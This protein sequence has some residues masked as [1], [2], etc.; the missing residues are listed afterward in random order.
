MLST[1]FLKDNTDAEAPLVD[2]VKYEKFQI[3]NEMIQSWEEHD[4]KILKQ[5]D[6]AYFNGLSAT[7][8]GPD[9]VG[10][11]TTG[12]LID[13]AN[14]NRIFA[15]STTSGLFLSLDNGASWNAVND[16]HKTLNYTSITQNLFDP[17]V[18]Y[19]G[20]DADDNI[21][22]SIDGGATFT[23]IALPNG[24]V[25]VFDLEHSKVSN[26][27]IFAATNDGLLKSTN[28]GLSWIELMDGEVFDVV[29]LPS[30]KVLAT[31]NQGIYSSQD[32]DPLS[33]SF[34]NYEPFTGYSSALVAK[35]AYS[36]DFPDHVYVLGKN[37]GD[38]FLMKSE[39]GGTNW[40]GVSG[41]PDLGH[42]AGQFMA[43]VVKKNDPEFI[44]IGGISGFG[45]Y[46]TDG[47]SSW[48]P[49][50]AGH[51]DQQIFLQHPANPDEFIIGNDGGIWRKNWSA[52]TDEPEDLNE[53]YGTTQFYFGD[54][55]NGMVIGGTQDNG[56][57]LFADGEWKNIRG[58][59]GFSCWISR[60]NP[61][62]AYGSIQNG[63]IYVWNNLLS[64]NPE[65]EQIG[66][67]PGDA[68]VAISTIFAMNEADDEQLYF[69]DGGIKR[70]T[71][72]G[73]SWE[74]IISDFVPT[75]IRVGNTVNPTLYY[76]GLNV[77]PIVNKLGK[78][79][80]AATASA[81]EEIDLSWK[82]P[83]DLPLGA[84]SS[85]A[86]HPQT[87]ELFI[88]S[89]SQSANHAKVWKLSNVDIQIEGP[90][91]PDNGQATQRSSGI[92]PGLPV[93]S[94]AINPVWPNNMII[95]TPYGVYET[96]DQ[97]GLWV[98]VSDI[99]NVRVDDIRATSD[100]KFVIFTY[101]RGIWELNRQDEP[102]GDFVTVPYSQNFE[103]PLDEEHWITN[104]STFFGEVTKTISIA[105]DNFCGNGKLL[106]R[107]IT[108]PNPS[109]NSATL[110]LDLKNVSEPVI[111]SF[112][113]KDNNA[114]EEIGGYADPNAGLSGI[115][116]S[117][118]AGYS[119]VK[120]SDFLPVNEYTYQT[121]DLS[122]LAASQGLALTQFMMLKF[123][124][125]QQPNQTSLIDNLTIDKNT[126]A[127]VPIL[128]SFSL[129]TNPYWTFQSTG[130]GEVKKSSEYI[131]QSVPS[132]LVMFGGSSQIGYD[133]NQAR[134]TIDLRD[135][136]PAALTFD[137]K[138]FGNE[139]HASNGV[140]FSDNGG[141]SFVKVLDLNTEEHFVYR[142]ETIMLKETINDLGLCPTRNFVIKFQHYGKYGPPM[143]G[144]LAFDNVSIIESPYTGDYTS[145][146]F[147]ENF[148]NP[149]SPS[150]WEKYAS[151]AYSQIVATQSNAYADFCSEGKLVM[152]TLINDVPSLNE[153]WLG[154]NL[155]NVLGSITL[156]FAYKDNYE[157]GG[158]TEEN[159]DPSF[160]SGLFLSN[161]RGKTFSQIA[162]IT[163]S[164]D[165]AYYTFNLS[166]LAQENNITLTETMVL[167]F[168]QYQQPGELVLIDNLMIDKGGIASTPYCEPF[169]GNFLQ[170]WSLS[171]TNDGVVR[172][173]YNPLV[174]GSGKLIMNSGP[175]SISY[176]QMR[177]DLRIDISTSND[178][179]ELSF[180]WK[181]LNNTDVQNANG[182]YLSDD[183]GLTFVKVYNLN[184]NVHNVYQN[185]VLNLTELMQANDLCATRDFVIRFQHYAKF[186]PPSFTGGF[187]FDNVCIEPAPDLLMSRLSIE[188]SFSVYPNPYTTG[189]NLSVLTN[190]E[191][192]VIELVD[193]NGKL[194]SRTRAG[195]VNESI[196][197]GI[198]K[199]LTKLA[200]IRIIP[201]DKSKRTQSTTIIRN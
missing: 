38:Y 63:H 110:K 171:K 3:T 165:F 20:T 99:P 69:I 35:I 141:A 174:K 14:T 186:G 76:A 106:L 83:E 176:D 201:D 46:S 192:V 71:D 58:A 168:Q 50:P 158:L 137:W 151:T 109:L 30:G 136:V 162:N 48:N 178:P 70:T 54:A 17:E 10:G 11:R 142:K 160:N 87:E 107:T 190:Y 157:I 78:M 124:L 65:Y 128:E 25:D 133:L 129:R 85:I 86:V 51:A 117:N 89:N 52:I 67:N 73:E 127:Q 13:V 143:A 47:G 196:E 154:I 88:T 184:T 42:Q 195:V 159:V 5:L 166:E 28:G 115:F 8:L 147:K 105:Y 41:V 23:E 198:D 200:Y 53:T 27:T 37:S 170:S 56:T 68:N 60:Q 16:Q 177:A 163:K 72:S 81:G 34:A 103:S 185:I 7:F 19:F 134:L 4:Q 199:V 172:V 55:Y 91:G 80:N 138:S 61:N 118:N 57:W 6:Q 111:V 66:P 161:D 173:D 181:S 153:A 120:I 193:G 9:K 49:F 32:G 2:F 43:I 101:G 24:V 156:S 189:G 148:E 183:G 144:G 122:A 112:A 100:G 90:E 188:N 123:Q 82:L 96:L 108:N 167:K 169:S 114:N 79:V 175:S 164:N 12:I 75:A 77:Y 45:Q 140:Y 98:K 93:N 95:G 125:Y 132:H 31:N 92:P 126:A 145:I 40:T 74:T 1:I 22:K 59:D 180:D 152:R 121:L 182:V 130:D 97:G 64:D 26:N 119:F 84:I 146:P 131:P 18:I 187:E 21:F 39:A 113:Y 62:K 94:I 36:Y 135:D 139:H 194:I 29:C 33:F 15:G 179:L 155:S 197:I 150:F 104:T 44:G 116:L 102:G 191:S 149:L